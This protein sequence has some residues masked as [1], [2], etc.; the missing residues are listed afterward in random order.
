MLRFPFFFDLRVS[1][2]LVLWMIVQLIG[3][4]VAATRGTQVGYDAHL[5]GALAGL[6]FWWLNG[7]GGTARLLRVA[8]AARR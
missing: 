4:I 2:A 1:G 7:W 3:A 5:G 8:S 6:I